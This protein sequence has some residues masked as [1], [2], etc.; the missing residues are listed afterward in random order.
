MTKHGGKYY[1]QYAFSGTEYNVYGDGVFVSGKPLGPFVPAENNPYSYAPGG[2]LPGAGHG[3][4]FQDVY[5]NWWHAATERVSVNHN[6][7]RRAG[8]WRA[9]FDADGELF[10]NQR[11]QD[12]PQ[13]VPEGSS[14]PW[15]E[16]EWFPLHPG[17][18]VE[19]SS[20][21]A[22]HEPE[23]AAEENIQTFWQA[24]SAAPGEWLELD[25]GAEMDVHAVQ[26]NFADG[27]LD[28]PMGGAEVDGRYI[29][30]VPG[31]T[32]WTLAGA[33]NGREFSVLADR[34]EAETD[35]PHECLIWENGKRLRYLRLTVL[36]VPYSQKPC[37]S[38]LRA[39]GKGGG[40]IPQVPRFTARRVGDLDMEISMDSAGA[41]GYN[42]LWGHAPEKLYHSRLTYQNALRIGALVKGQD[43]YIRVDAFNENGIAH[44]QT[45]PLS[46]S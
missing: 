21:S 24:A 8:L 7:E 22:G 13:T 23:K 33:G 2:F 40:E 42:V 14:D 18:R 10:C 26:I 4:T 44:G 17:K 30:P 19:A 27:K 29:D 45:V 35:L 34:A 25:L 38:G 39:F 3:S 12:W 41:S 16:P 46:G 6:F 36:E 31:R 20:Y 43:Y 5:G 11:W 1:L 32:R 37:I 9:G 28:L 15:T